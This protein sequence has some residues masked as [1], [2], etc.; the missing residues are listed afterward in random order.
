V[1]LVIPTSFLKAPTWM[2]LIH[3]DSNSWLAYLEHD[4]RLRLI[5]AGGPHRYSTSLGV[6]GLLFRVEGHRG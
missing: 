6:R 5:E 4:S 3:N 2:N 1:L